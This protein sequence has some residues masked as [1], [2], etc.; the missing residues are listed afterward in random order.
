MARGVATTVSLEAAARVIAVG[1]L[2][3]TAMKLGL[4][5]FFGTG[6]E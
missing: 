5:V 2:A 6:S 1:V 4:A 3:S